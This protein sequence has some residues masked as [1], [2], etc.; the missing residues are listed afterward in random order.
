MDITY[1]IGMLCRLEKSLKNDLSFLGKDV[2][3]MRWYFYLNEEEME[4]GLF[5]EVEG[6]IISWW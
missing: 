4:R 5:P 1:L 6:R 3:N 2:I